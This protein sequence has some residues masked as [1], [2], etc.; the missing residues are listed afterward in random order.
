MSET[1]LVNKILVYVHGLRGKAIKIHGSV[2]MESGTPDILGGI[3]AVNNR[4]VRWVHFF[5]E[6]K[7]PGNDPTPIQLHR[8]RE[9]QAVGYRTGVVRSLEDFIR[10]ISD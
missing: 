1:Q 10:V 8:L 7:L 5:V 9:W 2:F 4:D 3:P 6:C